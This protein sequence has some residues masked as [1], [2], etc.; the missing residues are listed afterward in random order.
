MLHRSIEYLRLR[1]ALPIV[2]VTDTRRNEIAIDHPTVTGIDHITVIDVE[3]P[4]VFNHHQAG[5]FLKTGLLRFLPPHREYAYLDTDVIAAAEGVDR[6]FD[7][8]S[9]PVTFAGDFTIRETCVATFS[10]WAVNCSCLNDGARAC[11]HLAQAID[12]KFGVGVRDD[13]IHWNGGV[14]L[15]GPDARAFM[16]TWHALTLR[17]FGDPYWRI[18][19]QGTLI[20]TV[21]ML[22]MQSQARLPEQYNFIVNLENP[23]LR[24]HRVE[25]YS[26]HKSL[27][28]IHPAF[29]HLLRAGLDRPDWSLKRDMEDLLAARSQ[30][31]A[32]PPTPCRPT[33]TERLMRWLPALSSEGRYRRPQ[34]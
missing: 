29:L 4:S 20:A 6:I 8:Q 22:G 15:F 14:F 27:P 33:R 18:R 31:A 26:H 24:F 1:S 25:G 10:P 7:F 16:E 9:G 12:R 11:S 30:P 32:V 21:W 2:I 28:A 34:S 3:T 13:W 19:D 17:I 5:I 23:D